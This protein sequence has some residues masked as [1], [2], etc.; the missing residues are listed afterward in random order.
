MSLSALWISKLLCSASIPVC[1][2]STFLPTICP[3][4][5]SILWLSTFTPTISCSSVTTTGWE[6]VIHNLS[7]YCRWA[8]SQVNRGTKSMWSAGGPLFDK[9][10]IRITV[11]LMHASVVGKGLIAKTQMPSQLMFCAILTCARV[12]RLR[13]TYSFSCSQAGVSQQILHSSAT[14]FPWTCQRYTP[15]ID[16]HIRW[17]QYI[18]PLSPQMPQSRAVWQTGIALSLAYFLASSHEL[19]QTLSNWPTCIVLR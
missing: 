1:N 16:G 14:Q 10:I 12:G 2:R 17:R 9:A 11:V 15:E 4:A 19:G 6:Q 8:A 7:L 5:P 3:L 13:V 18:H